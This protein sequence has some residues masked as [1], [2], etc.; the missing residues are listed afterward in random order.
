MVTSPF[1]ALSLP[2]H[3]V[4]PDDGDVSDLA[5]FKKIVGDARVVAVGESAH[6]IHEFYRIKDRL[7]RYL[8]NELGF[9]AFVLESGFAEAL[10]VN[11]WIMGGPG[12]IDAI[13]PAGVCYGFDTEDLRDQF[14][15]MREWNATHDRKLS[16][17]GLDVPG[18][19]TKPLPA[20]KACLNRLTPSPSDSELLRRAGLGDR[21]Q[22]PMFYSDLSQ[23]DRDGFWKG[24]S[25]LAARAEAE[26]DDVALRCARGVEVIRPAIEG[27]LGGRLTPGHN[28]RDAFM[29]DTVQW[30]LQREE[31]IMISAHNAHIM[32]RDL[33]GMPVLGSYLAPALGSD[34][35][36]IGTTCA[37]GKVIRVNK[38]L[39]PKNWTME[40]APLSSPPQGTLD[41]A[42][43]VA[44]SDLHLVDI[45]QLSDEQLS[46]VTTM[47]VHHDAVPI[48]P[49]G[50]DALIHVRHVST[51]HQC[52][53]AIVREIELGRSERARREQTA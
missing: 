33:M 37:E 7:F 4:D 25:G 27:D 31:R 38:L 18:S 22:V 45:G 34:M 8:V 10:A 46:D 47:L 14:R 24:V 32:K 15:W 13:A 9:T 17:Y 35:V 42:M 48:D 5:P 43:D 11:E 28:P 21:F 40:L 3:T 6:G 44:P 16:F 49:R 41:A 20:I 23:E 12:E 53:D 30:I 36:I 50:F 51:A 39:D 1:E 29:A 52:F 2:L 19:G 26:Q